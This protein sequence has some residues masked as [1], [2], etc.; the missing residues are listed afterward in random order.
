LLL[1]L[2]FL[3]AGCMKK[4]SY[5]DT[6][7]IGLNSFTLIFDS[8]A[9]AKQGVLSVSFTDGNG[10]IGLSEGDTLS[11][12]ERTGP[13]YY[14][15]VISYFEKQNG[16]FKPIPLTPPFSGRIPILSPGDPGKAIKGDIVDTLLMNP[17][18]VYDTVKFEVFLYDRA[19]HKSN[20]LSTPEIILRRP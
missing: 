19:L 9:Y 12:Y 5:P 18:P 6:P 16:I 11:P 2:L 17:M 15:F 3:A 20:T 4:Q 13:Y 1:P 14:N 8:A 10:D 7:Q